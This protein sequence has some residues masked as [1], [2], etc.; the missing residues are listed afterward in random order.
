MDWQLEL[1]KSGRGGSMENK[2]RLT[3]AP[4]NSSE[5]YAVEFWREFP[6]RWKP[7]ELA[8]FKKG[9]MII[10]TAIPKNFVDR[11]LT[12]FRSRGI[13]IQIY[14]FEFG[15]KTLSRLLP[16]LKMTVAF[17]PDVVIGIGGGTL[18]DIVGFTASCYQRGIPHILF[19]TTTLGMVDASIG[20]K[21]AIDFAGVKNSIGAIHFPILVV[22]S[23][24]V[25]DSLDPAEF[26][27]GFAE[28]I[29]AA[30]LFDKD[31][32]QELETFSHQDMMNI[33]NDRFLQI[34]RHSAYLK[35]ENSEA[36]TNHKI[37]LLYGHA[38]GHG[39][40]LLGPSKRRH[41]DCVAIGMNIEGAIACFKGIWEFKEW[42]AQRRLLRQ[43]R[44]PTV[45]PPDVNIKT[46]ISRM[47]LYKKLTSDGSFL[48]VFP[49][50]FGEVYIN[51][52]GGFT[53]AIDKN[54]FEVLLKKCIEL[55]KKE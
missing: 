24:D 29:K 13:K 53:T 47:C 25:L 43:F 26:W 34:I 30:V 40:E 27:A 28:I 5:S 12:S 48:F 35:M 54:E 11:I 46:L 15:P 45:F 51:N 22:N 2:H 3:Y 31:F 21:T 39:L 8:R 14:G 1:E 41:G 52:N 50:H 18:S 38:I 19:P 23:L 36:H 10:D 6:R 4:F 33:R 17:M 32:F 55:D 9:L 7:P 16:I 37:K 44:L 49:K 20:G 42:E